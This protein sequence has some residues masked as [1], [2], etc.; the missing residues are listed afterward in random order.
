MTFQPY[1]NSAMGLIYCK[2]Y[3]IKIFSKNYD[4]ESLEKF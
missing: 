1:G 4:E 2:N 3:M